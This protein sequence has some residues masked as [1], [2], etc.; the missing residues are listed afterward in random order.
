MQTMSSKIITGG[1]VRVSR[2]LTRNGSVMVYP[3]QITDPM[4]RIARRKIFRKHFTVNPTEAL[5][6]DAGAKLRDYLLINEGDFV[7][8]NENIAQRNDRKSRILTAKRSGR[9]L[10]IS[11][12]TLVFESD[13][14]DLESV[15]AGFPGKVAEV[16]PNRGAFLETEGAYIRG[17][18]GNGH[19]GQGIILTLDDIEHDGVFTAASLSM[20]MSG[21]VIYAH[22]CYDAD[23]LSSVAKQSP[24][25]L[26]FGALP[27]DLLPV[28]ASLP[29]PVVV[30]DT[31][32]NGRI[33]SPIYSLLGENIIK[34]AYLYSEGPRGNLPGGS[35]III[36]QDMGFSAQ[37]RIPTDIEVGSRVRIL[38][39]YYNG[40]I[41]YVTEV[42]APGNNTNGNTEQ[43]GECVRICIDENT[44][45]VLPLNNV[46]L[47]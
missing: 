17:I 32:G 40:E 20:A 26:I 25:G 28:A 12:G 13:D 34:C 2:Q 37:M 24:G 23:V 4:T 9:F 45:T 46:E 21:A 18:W 39:G 35:E 11:A 43:I 7:S 44:E 16:V 1:T 33:G 15:L 29:F 38:D 8:V 22:T 10:G 41:G 5:E 42:L 47:L 19:I 30:T 36:P 14:E 31:I 3:G 27:A 6:L